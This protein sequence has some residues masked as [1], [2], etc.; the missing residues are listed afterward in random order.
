M[1]TKA[2]KDDGGLTALVMRCAF[3][4]LAGQPTVMCSSTGRRPAGFPRGELMSIGTNGAQNFAVNPV[5]AMAWV[6]ARTLGDA[7]R[8]T[9]ST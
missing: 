1:S 6:H 2:D 4:I 9:A 7:Q 5:K 3:A 8:L